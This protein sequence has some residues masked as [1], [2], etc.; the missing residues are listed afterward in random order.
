MLMCKRV[1]VMSFADDTLIPSTTAIWWCYF[2]LVIRICYRLP[3]AIHTTGVHS[4][5]ARVVH[6]SHLPLGLSQVLTQ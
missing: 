6:R 3:N 5:S 1:N 4:S 2:T